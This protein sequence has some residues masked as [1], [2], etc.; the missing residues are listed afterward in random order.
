MPGNLDLTFIDF[1]DRGV[2]N[3]LPGIVGTQTRLVLHWQVE[4]RSGRVKSALEDV[5]A[6]S[7]VDDLL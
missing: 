2:S 7:M 6:D 4:E 1:R 3:W 5:S